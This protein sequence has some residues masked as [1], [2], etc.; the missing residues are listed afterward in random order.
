MS[1][2]DSHVE[3]GAGDCW[4]PDS[5]IRLT[6]RMRMFD[7]IKIPRLELTLWETSPS[8]LLATEKPAQATSHLQAEAWSTCTALCGSLPA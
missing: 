3:L 6:T 7:P 8:P 5:S 4:A 2:E 1:S